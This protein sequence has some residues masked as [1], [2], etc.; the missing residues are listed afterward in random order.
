MTTSS[1]SV[2]V[3]SELE[4]FAHARNW[5]SYWSSRLLD[6]VRGDV[7]EVGAGLGA[8]TPLLCSISATAWCFIEPDPHMAQGLRTAPPPCVATIPHRVHHGMLRDLPEQEKFDTLI[9]IDVLE[10]IADDEAEVH[11]AMERLRP[12]G[13]LIALSPAFQWLFSPFD[14]AVGHHRRY[15]KAS[16]LPLCGDLGRVVDVGYLDSLG[17]LLSLGNRLFTR[18]SAPEICQI[19]AW[20][21]W[22]VPLSRYVVDP[23]ASRLIGRS[24]FA[25]WER[26]R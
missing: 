3:G 23:L 15:T 11:L 24:V 7:G 8:S 25:V 5:K 26:S 1:S 9:Y 14:A 22:V 16:L 17:M 19:I 21:T 20:D 10:H 18:Q 4:L 6:H 12:G 2:Y 13:R